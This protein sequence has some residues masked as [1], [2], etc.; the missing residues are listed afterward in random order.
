MARN[1]VP[2][3]H[4]TEGARN[5]ESAARTPRPAGGGAPVGE[6]APMHYH[7]PGIVDPAYEYKYASAAGAAGRTDWGPGSSTR[8]GCG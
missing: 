1:R 2:K 8:G 3:G 4:L 6:M 7:G 5:R